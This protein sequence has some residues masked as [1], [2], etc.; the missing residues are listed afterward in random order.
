MARATGSHCSDLTTCSDAMG[1]GGTGGERGWF[2][3]EALCGPPR[4]CTHGLASTVRARKR[5]CRPSLR[6]GPSGDTPGQLLLRG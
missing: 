2:S 5:L 3:V 6:F 1:E 4:P